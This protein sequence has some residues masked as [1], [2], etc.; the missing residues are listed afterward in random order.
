M[1]GAELSHWMSV[2][3]RK[4]VLIHWLEIFIHNYLL[5]NYRFCVK[6]TTVISQSFPSVPSLLHCVSRVK[7][8]QPKSQF[9]TGCMS[10]C[11]SRWEGCEEKLVLISLQFLLNIQTG[12]HCHMTDILAPCPVAQRALCMAAS[13]NTGKMIC[14]HI[15]SQGQEDESKARRWWEV[16]V[17][18]VKS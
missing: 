8:N 4:H 14:T 15:Q 3:S 7:R 5:D 9:S 2:F 12:S 16:F 11:L 13:R 18:Y 17:T 6:I 1:C 10:L